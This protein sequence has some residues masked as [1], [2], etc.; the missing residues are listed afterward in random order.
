MGQGENHKTEFAYLCTVVSDVIRTA[1][2]F[3]GIRSVPNALH[4]IKNNLNMAVMP[5]TLQRLEI[6]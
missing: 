6:L 5:L 1:M 2:N 3:D 4:D